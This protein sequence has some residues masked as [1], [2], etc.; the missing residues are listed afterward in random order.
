M[1]GKV[2][3]NNRAISGSFRRDVMFVMTS[4]M[5]TRFACH[6]GAYSK[7]QTYL[8]RRAI[9]RAACWVWPH[10]GQRQRP[11]GGVPLRGLSNLDASKLHPRRREYATHLCIRRIIG[12]LCRPQ[13]RSQRNSRRSRGLETKLHAQDA[14]SRRK[15]KAFLPAVLERGEEAVQRVRGKWVLKDSWKPVRA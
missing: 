5:I 2:F 10:V 7:V 9:E 12:T 1:F 14:P 4:C 13:R 11:R 8:D 15:A 6:R 3:S